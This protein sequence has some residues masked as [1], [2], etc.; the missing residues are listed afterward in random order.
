V[1]YRMGNTPDGP[2]DPVTRI[3]PRAL[4]IPPGFPDFMS[5]ARFVKAGQVVLEGRAWS[6]W[7]PIAG[8]EVS[9]DGGESWSAARLDNAQTSP[10][11]WRGWNWSWD[12]APGRYEL[13]VR[14]TDADGRTQPLEQ[15]WNRGGFASNL[16]QRVPVAV[17]DG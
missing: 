17:I 11:A 3:E 16:V 6:G 1:A 15:P 7:A 2:G 13:S 9:T 8:V 14:A 12:A 4:L 5:R 10:W